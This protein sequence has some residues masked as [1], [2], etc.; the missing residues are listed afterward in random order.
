MKVII[1]G[2][3]LCGLATAIALRKHVHLENEQLEIKIYEKTQ[4]DPSIEAKNEEEATE[5]KRKLG[6]A[7]NLQ[8]NGLLVLRDLDSALYEK[9]LSRGYPCKHMT[10]KT[11]SDI[12][13]G[14]NYLDV[15]PISRPVLIEC[16]QE[17]LPE[18]SV[19]YKTV[20]EVV[21]SEHSRPKVCFQDGSPDEEADLVVG[22]DGIRSPV[23]NCLFEPSVEHHP[24]Y[25]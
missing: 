20:V 4:L 6:A 7:V 13:L 16:L 3:G 15:L 23:R 5:K 24:V 9:V 8:Q 2:A 17:C 19:T 25:T 22:A 12:T 21:V 18:D 14:R 1:I 11:S 10:W